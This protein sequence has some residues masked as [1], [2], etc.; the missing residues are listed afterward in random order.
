VSDYT[1]IDGK[2][3]TIL[4]I[5]DDESTR[6][7]VAAALSD[8]GYSVISAA[9]TEE[10]AQIA[11]QASPSLILLDLLMPGGGGKR[12]LDVHRGN[13]S[14]PVPV[15]VMTAVSNQELRDIEGLADGV[16]TKPFELDDL[17]TVVQRFC[18]RSL[19]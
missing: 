5:E 11:L 12:F 19:L 17:L 10:G 14:E 6:W 7:F 2:G 1:P 8:E 18:G 3:P 16:L 9:D 13:G 15:V 4:V